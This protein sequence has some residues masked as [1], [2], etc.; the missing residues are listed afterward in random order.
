[1]TGAILVKKQSRERNTM[2][3]IRIFKAFKG[4]TDKYEGTI[5]CSKDLNATLN[6]IRK[7]QGKGLYRAGKLRVAKD[8]NWNTWHEIELQVQAQDPVTK[9]VVNVVES[10]IFRVQYYNQVVNQITLDMKAVDSK[11]TYKEF[12]AELAKLPDVKAA[13]P[14]PA[15]KE[16]PIDLSEKTMLEALDLFEKSIIAFGENVNQSTFA[17]VKAIKAEIGKKIATLDPKE[18]AAFMSGMSKIDVFVNAISS[19]FANPAMASSVASFAATYVS[20]M[21]AEVANLQALCS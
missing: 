9:R 6:L 13:T 7:Y 19:Q 12:E 18:K 5:K 21:L 8:V 1:M 15:V 10:I 4:I 2:G 3:I 11:A 17:K 14:P 20:Q 16:E